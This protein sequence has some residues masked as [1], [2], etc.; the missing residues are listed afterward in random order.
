M[1][2]FEQ[3]PFSATEF[4]DNPEPRCPCL[5]L[6]DTSVSMQGNPI[7]ELNAGLATFKQELMGDSLAAKRV[8]VSIV[9]FG[10]VNVAVDF[11]TADYFHPADA[12]DDRRHSHGRCDCAGDRSH[13]PAQGNV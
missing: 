7:R 11:T 5:L 10:P 6:L 1:S 2:E 13:P 8:E 4:A 9:T 3:V 12:L